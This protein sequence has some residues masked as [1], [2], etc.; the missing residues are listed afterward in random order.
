MTTPS[1]RSGDPLADRRADYAEAYA[2]AGDAAAAADLMRQAL[3]LAPDW[4]LGRMRLASFLEESGAAGDA[5]RVYEAVAAADPADPYG[6]GLKLAALGQAPAPAAPPPR[7]VAGLF[8]QYAASFETQLVER[9]GYRVPETLFAALMEAAGAGAR[10]ARALDL[11]CGTGLM[12]QR[13]RPVSDRLDGIDLSAGMLEKARA[14]GIY[15]ALTEGD[16]LEARSG[17]GSLYDCIAAADVLTYL[18]DLAPVFA[19]VASLLAPGGLFAFSVEADDGANG[20]AL[21]PSL[22]YA[23]APAELAGMLREAGFE[24]QLDRR[25]ELR[26]DRGEP[27]P[28]ALMVA[29]REG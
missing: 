6:A 15:D 25:T 18:G 13:L 24:L 2:K 10:F 5:A 1:H 21:K 14:K 22:R 17:D 11:G 8:D 4:P 16:V 20:F 29:R 12:G 7:F 28:G 27:V 19:R 26:R 3:D 23:H 9:L